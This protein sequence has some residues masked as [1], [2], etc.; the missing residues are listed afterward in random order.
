MAPPKHVTEG[1]QARQQQSLLQEHALPLIQM[2]AGED[3]YP[4]QPG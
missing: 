3:L 2:E 1:C 4:L